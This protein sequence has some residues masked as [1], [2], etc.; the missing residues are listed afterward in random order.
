MGASNRN[1]RTAV[2][3]TSVAFFFVFLAFVTPY[4]LVF[5]G[6]LSANQQKFNN[7]GLW[8]VCLV[9][10]QD[11]HKWYDTLF[12][13]C[14]WVFEEEYYI[15]HDYLL[16]GFYIATQF[17][18]TLTFVLSFIGILFMF[19][20]LRSPRDD[21]RYIFILLT[22]GA[23]Q[24]FGGLFG[25]IACIIWAANGD[26]RD[27]MPHWGNNN[28]GWSYACACLG[29][30]IHIPAGSLFMV[31]ARR[32]RYKRLNEISNR[33]A[34][35]EYSPDDYPRSLASSSKTGVQTDI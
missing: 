29:T 12:N 3:L 15:I 4:W 19:V 34:A 5:D 18:F 32:E 8:E 24:V 33:E 35:S 14:M 7:L 25:L 30:L 16:P 28:M 10:F 11:I 21:D 26:S 1:T 23:V 13:G 31:Q 2:I 17:F 27:W 9:R 22:T 20:F 6:K